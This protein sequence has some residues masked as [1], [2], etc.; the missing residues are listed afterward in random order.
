MS[1]PAPLCYSKLEMGRNAAA[2]K[3]STIKNSDPA[4]DR[5]AAVGAR[6]MLVGS[7]ISTGWRLAIMVLAPIIL[8][9]QLDKRLDSSPTYTLAAF[10]IAITGSG[11]LI[12]KTYG[13]IQKQQLLSEAKKSKRKTRRG[14][15]A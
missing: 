3:R 5:L 6:N 4:V 11:L 14:A 9:A 1:T 8:G 2:S 10:C 15:H 12:Y 7:M 13:D